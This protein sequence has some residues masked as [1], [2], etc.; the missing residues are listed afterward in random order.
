MKCWSV[1]GAFCVLTSLRWV[2]NVKLTSVSDFP[3]YW[4]LQILHSIRYI[5]RKS[6]K[7]LYVF[8]VTLVLKYCRCRNWLHQKSSD[9]EKQWKIQYFSSWR[10][11]V[12]FRPQYSWILVD[13]RGFCSFLRLR[14]V[15]LKTSLNSW[16]IWSKFQLLVIAQCQ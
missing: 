6:W 4:I 10:A 14:I 2:F 15:F 7:I 5:N 16:F 8:C 13:H 1:C 12:V 3:I 9:F 11:S